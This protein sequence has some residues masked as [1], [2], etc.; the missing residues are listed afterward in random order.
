MKTPAL[1][2][3]LACSLLTGCGPF[4]PEVCW[5][6]EGKGASK[7][8][9]TTRTL[10]NETPRLDSESFRLH[11]EPDL[12]L[13]QAADRA[14]GL[15]AFENHQVCEQHVLLAVEGA[16]DPRWG[17]TASV[18]SPESIDDVSTVLQN[19]SCRDDYAAQFRRFVVPARGT[20]V[21]HLSAPKNQSGSYH[22]P[23]FVLANEGCL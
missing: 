18:T 10:D 20:V 7:V 17:V 21:L 16:G 13:A 3:L 4:D 1:L 2:L 14:E 22:L 8:I 15:V 5:S 6:L 9:K 19:A 11:I 23:M 12:N